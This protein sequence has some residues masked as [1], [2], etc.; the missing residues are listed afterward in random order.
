MSGLLGSLDDFFMSDARRQSLLE[1]QVQIAKARGLL[2]QQAA[3]SRLLGGNDPTAVNPATDRSPATPADPSI[4]YAPVTAPTGFTPPQPDAGISGQ[5]FDKK[6]QD[7]TYAQPLLGQE[8]LEGSGMNPDQAVSLMNGGPQAEQQMKRG[9]LGQAMPEPFMQAQATQAI[10]QPKIDALNLTPEERSLAA[11]DPQKFFDAKVASAIPKPD[12]TVQKIKQIN[13]TISSFGGPDDPRS[14][15]YVEQLRVLNHQTDADI[16]KLAEVKAATQQHLADAGKAEAQTGILKSSGLTD[17]TLNLMYEQLKAGQPLSQIT[18]TFR[19]PQA[20]QQS[21]AFKNYVS[22]RAKQ[23]GL[24]GGDF[25]KA[26]QDL[27]ASTD[28]LVAFDK[29]KEGTDVRRANTAFDHLGQVRALGDALDNGDLKT[30]NEITNIFRNEFNDPNLSG[31]E[32][33]AK[34]AGDE[35]NKFVSGGP[36]AADDRLAYA[37][38]LSSSKDKASRDAAINGLQGLLAGQLSQYERQYRVGTKRND[39]AERLSPEAAKMLQAH[40]PQAAGG[41]A[42]PSPVPGIPKVPTIQEGA[43]VTNKATGQKLMLKNGQWVPA[44]G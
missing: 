33:V 2:N 43:T 11:V 42:T 27:K 12:E 9:L 29:G 8:R 38:S 39:F 1:K 41:T 36:G 5:I 4:N 14:K 31:Y 35:V 22:A 32:A 25:A 20:A 13:D 3:Q 30:A 10:M 40:S 24:V 21:V 34:V 26:M 6:P 18:G 16:A 37:K 23:D 7:Y 19:G 28:T 17:D 15:P 44:N